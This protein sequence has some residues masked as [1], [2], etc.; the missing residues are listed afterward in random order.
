MRTHSYE[1][2]EITKLVVSPEGADGAVIAMHRAVDSV[3]SLF[4]LRNSSLSSKVCWTAPTWSRWSISRFTDIVHERRGQAGSSPLL[5]GFRRDT[6]GVTHL[7]NGGA[8]VKFLGDF[9][10]RNIDARSSEWIA[11]S[12]SRMVASSPFA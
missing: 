2:L 3:Y 6:E 1:V 4:W 5:R 9:G 11:P 7:R 10:F 12:Q 8:P